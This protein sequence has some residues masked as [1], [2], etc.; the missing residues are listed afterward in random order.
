MTFSASRVSIN[1]KPRRISAGARRWLM[2]RAGST[3]AVE[4]R[5]HE[6]VVAQALVGAA[7][8]QA[9]V[10]GQWLGAPASLVRAA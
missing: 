5:L 7:G 3:A 8:A 10:L 1:S 4:R 9:R 6:F 2:K